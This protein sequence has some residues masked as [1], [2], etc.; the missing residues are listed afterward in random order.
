MKRKMNLIRKL[1]ILLCLASIGILVCS[2]KKDDTVVPAATSTPS[3]DSGN[4]E[5]TGIELPAEYDNEIWT[6][7]FWENDISYYEP[8]SFTEDETGQLVVGNLFYEPEEILE[9]RSGVG[10]AQLYKDKDFAYED[11]KFNVTSTILLVEGRDYTVKNGKIRLTSDKKYIDVMTYEELYPFYKE[12]EEKTWLALPS[13]NSR[14]INIDG[15]IKNAQIYVTYTHKDSWSGYV[16]AA[17][18]EHLPA[19]MSKLENKEA[20]NFVIYGDSIATGAD[21]SGNT[22]RVIDVNTLKEVSYNSNTAPKTPSWAEMVTA[23]LET[24]YG[25]DGIV[26]INRAAGSSESSWGAKNVQTL[27]CSDD[28]KIPDV[29]VI[30]FGMNEPGRTGTAFKANLNTMIDTVLAK[31]PNCE[32][33]LMSSIE[34]NPMYGP[35]NL[36]EHEKAM[37][38]LQN[39]RTDVHIAVCPVNSV[40]HGML[41]EGKTF[42]DLT[43]NN[44]NHPNDFLGRV[45]A[46]TLLATL[47]K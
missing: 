28:N 31:N 47:G 41:D 13:D 17:Q 11:G 6:K 29:V 25:Y 10:F 39:E 35:T 16:P 4:K 45:Y 42:Y 1:I 12:G 37:Y 14:Y 23:R 9:V 3:S 24:L 38:E 40:Y 21:C 46:M 19:T 43:S 30:A 20:L 44:I 27:L 2:C 15:T 32:F 33:I 5:E 36:S 8:I 7:K 26:K 18:T 22:E 34:S